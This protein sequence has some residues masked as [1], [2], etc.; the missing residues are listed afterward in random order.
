M[1]TKQL[2]KYDMCSEAIDLISSYSGFNK[3]DITLLELKKTLENFPMF[4][5]FRFEYKNNDYLFE[6]KDNNKNN[7]FL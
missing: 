6:I 1:K 4:T 5:Y 7:K 2:K 3:K